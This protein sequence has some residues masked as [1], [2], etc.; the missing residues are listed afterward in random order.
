MTF[1][2]HRIYYLSDFAHEERKRRS[3]VNP[4]LRR[5]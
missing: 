1:G 2:T 5:S 4:L 3:S